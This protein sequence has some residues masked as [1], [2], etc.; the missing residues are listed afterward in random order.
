MPFLP[1]RPTYSHS[2]QPQILELSQLY[3]F[4]LTLIH[5]FIFIP[6]PFI[7][8]HCVPVPVAEATTTDRTDSD[9]CPYCIAMH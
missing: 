3:A 2:V 1:P 4:V 5:S 9:P 8:P 7:E 6:Q